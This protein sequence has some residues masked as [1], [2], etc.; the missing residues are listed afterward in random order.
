MGVICTMFTDGNETG[1]L[2]G[3]AVVPRIGETIH[4]PILGEIQKMYVVDV[5]HIPALTEL[6]TEGEVELHVTSRRIG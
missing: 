1:E 4:M 3:F 5:V 2:F 6:K